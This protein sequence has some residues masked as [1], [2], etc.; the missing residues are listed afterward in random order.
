MSL[1]LSSE[2]QIDGSAE[3]NDHDATS[4]GTRVLASKGC[5]CQSEFDTRIDEVNITLP[6]HLPSPFLLSRLFMHVF[7]SLVIDCTPTT[8]T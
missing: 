7:G 3:P 1:T 8:T 4:L 5:I 6:P 2:F